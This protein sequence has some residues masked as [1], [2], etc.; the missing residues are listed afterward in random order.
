MISSSGFIRIDLSCFKVEAKKGKNVN[1]STE[2][3]KFLNNLIAL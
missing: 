1:I 2:F 3:G